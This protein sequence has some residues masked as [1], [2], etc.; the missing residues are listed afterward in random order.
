MAASI[1]QRG[2]LGCVFLFRK[3][4]PV[5]HYAETLLAFKVRPSGSASGSALSSDGLAVPLRGFQRPA[6]R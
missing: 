6:K 2:G 4:N 1:R 3:S 5:K